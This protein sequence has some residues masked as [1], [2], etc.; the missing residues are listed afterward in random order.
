MINNITN[1]HISGRLFL[2]ALQVKVSKLSGV[3]SGSGMDLREER[4]VMKSITKK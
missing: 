4:E 1:R 3:K 2:R